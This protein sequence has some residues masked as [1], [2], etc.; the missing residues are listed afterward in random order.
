VWNPETRYLVD[1]NRMTNTTIVPHTAERYGTVVLIRVRPHHL[2][3]VIGVA[4]CTKSYLESKMIRKSRN[5]FLLPSFRYS[6]KPSE[7][8]MYLHSVLESE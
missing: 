4:N 5:P 8:L 3:I 2:C 6:K 7:L 1:T